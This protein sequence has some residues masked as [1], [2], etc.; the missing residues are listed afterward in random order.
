MSWNEHIVSLKSIML[1]LAVF[2]LE[3]RKFAGVSSGST[4]ELNEQLIEIWT[5]QKS[6]SKWTGFQF[7]WQQ[8]VTAVFWTMLRPCV[9]ACTFVHGLLPGRRLQ[10]RAVVRS[11]SKFGG[12]HGGRRCGLRRGSAGQARRSVKSCCLN[13]V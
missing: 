6:K 11:G 1:R 12:R 2:R 8:K 7:V 9:A 10:W 4:S 13:L 3:N 5:S